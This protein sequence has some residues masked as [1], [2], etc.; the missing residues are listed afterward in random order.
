MSV[1][2]EC[3]VSCCICR[4]QFDYH[5]RVGEEACCCSKECLTRFRLRYATSIT[6]FQPPMESPDE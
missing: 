1:F 3:F 2:R 6:E 5:R 4:S